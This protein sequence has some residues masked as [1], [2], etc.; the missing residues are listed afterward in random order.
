MGQKCRKH[1]IFWG[2]VCEYEDLECLPSTSI[3]FVSNLI[4]CLHDEGN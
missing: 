4:L 2:I 1:V 3:S